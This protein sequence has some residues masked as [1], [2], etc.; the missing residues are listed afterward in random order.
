MSRSI[1][2]LATRYIWVGLVE[3]STLGTVRMYPEPGDGEVDLRSMPTN[4]IIARILV[5]V[6]ALHEGEPVVSVGAGFPGIVRCGVIDDSPNLA[7]LK[8]VDMRERLGVA[9]RAA[10]IDAP[11][12]VMNDAD[13]LA[14]GIAA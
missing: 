4:D 14:A 8:G 1:G 3:G 12:S 10:G 11:V 5:Q 6:E 9:L 2:A 7:Q 13:A